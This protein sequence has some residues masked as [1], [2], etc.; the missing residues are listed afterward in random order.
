ML[1]LRKSLFGGMCLVIQP[2]LLNILSLP[3]MAYIIRGLGPSN[4]GQ[5]TMAI[6]LIGAIG[7]LAN[8]GLRGAFIRQVAAEPHHASK[9]L[10]EQLGLRLVLATVAA[11]VAILLCLIL[12]YP[13]VAIQ[14]AAIGAVGMI[15]TTLATTLIDVLQAIGRTATG[16]GVNLIAG[17]SLTAASIIVIRFGM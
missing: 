14:C 15:V 12:K 9:A 11:S 2:L 7:I 4:Y 13:L 1:T 17:L 3:V 10:A 5:W 8:L 16:A 6:A